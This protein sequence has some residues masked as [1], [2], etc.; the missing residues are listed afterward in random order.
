ML[1]G[2][3]GTKEDAQ[4]LARH[5]TAPT[6][7]F[8]LGID[9]M[10]GGYLL[11]TGEQGLDVIDKRKLRDVD[12]P[13]TELFAAMQA[14][15][16]MWSYGDGKIDNA[17]LKRSMRILLDRPNLAD[18]AIT[19]LARWKDWGVQQ[20]LMKLYD[21]QDY[22]AEHVKRAI[23]SYIIASTRDMPKHAKKLPKHVVQG[24]KYLSKLRK[25]DPQIVRRAERFFLPN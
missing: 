12:G 2:L 15:R 13:T 19:D 24:R 25:K 8:R 16:F 22:Q 9:G 7:E 17:R 23:V 5:I 20:R 18:I 21:H 14:L 11:L 6:K 4:L 10:I 3:C 1:L